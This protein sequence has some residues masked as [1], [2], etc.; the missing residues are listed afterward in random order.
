MRAKQINE[1]KNFE[2]GQ[3]PKSAMG[4]GVKGLIQSKIPQIKEIDK[5]TGG[6]RC[7]TS[8]EFY[9]ED[10]QLDIGT[11]PGQ[12]C[13]GYFKNMLKKLGI[14]DYFKLDYADS[15]SYEFKLK[16]EYLN[17]TQNFERGQDPKA[18][19]GIGGVELMDDYNE[20]IS[21]L[22]V[23]IED[24]KSAYSESYKDY[25]REILPGKKITAK[26]STLP[27]I[28]KDGKS[29]GKYESGEFTI[30]VQDAMPSGNIGEEATRSGY[31]AS[32]SLVVADMEGNM[33]QLNLD[34][35]IRIS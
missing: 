26:M 32:P 20:R 33:Y 7:V 5:A 23:D 8:V 25:I 27:T 16:P 4:L 18:A 28:S 12:L 31:G 11:Y 19:M 1:V 22:K 9:P 6:W 34:Q 17:E 35:K 10:G 15:T 13:R 29:K 21:D 14:G 3:D 30:T 2:R 24:L